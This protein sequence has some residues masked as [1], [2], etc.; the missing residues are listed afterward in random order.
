M[1]M[2][3]EGRM[4]EREGKGGRG[5][6]LDY[7]RVAEAGGDMQRRQAA[8]VDFVDV[9]APETQR[10]KLADDACCRR[11]C[12]PRTRIRQLDRLVYGERRR[13]C[14]GGAGWLPVAHAL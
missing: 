4:W 2:R 7:V 3:K 6:E 13:G 14:S 8:L 5:L 11:T 10:H 9:A 12:P 1:K